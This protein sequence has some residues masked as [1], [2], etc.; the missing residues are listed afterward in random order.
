MPSVE[1]RLRIALVVHGYPPELRGGTERT[2]QSL[3]LGLLRA[4]HEPLV[5][6]GSDRWQDGFRVSR[7]RE[8]DPESGRSFPVVRIHRSDVHYGHWTKRVSPRAG[9]AF[10]ELL[11]ELRPDVVH[12]HHW[13]RLSSDLVVRSARLGVPAVVTLHDHASSC[14]IYFRVRPGDLAFCEAPLGAEPC[15]DCASRVYP[16]TPWLTRAEEGLVLAR[17]QRDLRRELQAARVV[18]A[19]SDDQAR[20]VER[21]I[22]FPLA[23]RTVAPSSNTSLPPAAPAPPIDRRDPG[24]PL[25]LGCWSGMHELKGTDV[26]LSAMRL[27]RERGV[28]VE[29]H[30]AGVEDA[31]YAERMRADAGGLAVRF[32]GPFESLAG[33]PVTRVHAFVAGTRARETWGVVLD[34]AVAL[35]LPL[36]VPRFG[37]YAT[38]L[39]DGEGVLFYERGDA[40]SLAAVLERMRREPGL[41]ADLRAR[42]PAHAALVPS[43]AA[44]T[45]EYLAL[46]RAAV[47]AGAPDVAPEDP[48]ELA[49]DE[50]FVERWDRG[51]RAEDE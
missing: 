44:H 36:V 42:L 35:R 23:I 32:H 21:L 51:G 40:H 43:L 33:H 50:A 48:A 19:L 5:I 2:V 45:S 26:L 30:L 10:E 31:A 16:P 25:V 28:P 3:A 34:E 41:L 20:T 4:G 12:V 18:A 22:G 15:L 14:L 46:Y 11:R 37:A 17:W 8:H 7:E 39:S 29:L 49:A 47:D 13:V 38:R 27:L 24:S 9:A 1:P 6:A